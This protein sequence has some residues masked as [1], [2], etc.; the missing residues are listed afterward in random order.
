MAAKRLFGAK[1]DYID[2]KVLYEINCKT[3]S[4][5][6]SYIEIYDEAKSDNPN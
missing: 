2:D 6:Q 1:I 3:F 5:P 4:D